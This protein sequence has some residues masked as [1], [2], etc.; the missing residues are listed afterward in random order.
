MGSASELPWTKIHEFL[1]EVGSTREPKELCVQVIK[2]IYRLIPYDQARVYFVNDFG[3]V[4][5]QVLIGVEQTWSDVYLE[6]YSRIENGRYS[7]PN[8]SSVIPDRIERGRYSFPNLEGGVYD[9][10][11]YKGDEFMAEYIRPQ[12]LNYSAG[13]AFHDADG[14]IKS[15]Y[16]LDRTGRNEY[17]RKEIDIMSVVQPHLDNLHQNLFVSESTRMMHENLAV[18]KALTKREA[19]IAELLCRGLTPIKIGRTL[20]LSLPTVY[21]HIANIHAKLNVSNRQELLLALLTERASPRAALPAS[22]GAD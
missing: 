16:M 11:S 20:S 22:P 6:H 15:V 4:Y 12:R 10:T 5:D 17:I 19:Q 9:W 13:F 7:I 14:F 18:Q 2:K 8:R 21:R 3:K 1:L